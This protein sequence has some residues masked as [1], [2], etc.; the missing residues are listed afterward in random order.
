MV[1]V[2]IIA[3]RYFTT[4]PYNLLMTIADYVDGELVP[5]KDTEHQFYLH[6]YENHR[7][8][9][10]IIYAMILCPEERLRDLVWACKQ[11]VDIDW[12]TLKEWA[13]DPNDDRKNVYAIL[14][15]I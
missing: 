8:H 10:N 5:Y 2:P 9:K 6:Y 1:P 13:A 4:T 12:D 15:K 14:E 11:G 7:D 3:Y